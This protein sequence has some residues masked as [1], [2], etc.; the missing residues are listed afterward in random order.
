LN[1]QIENNPSFFIS[2]SLKGIKEYGTKTPLE[3]QNLA[4]RFTEIAKSDWLIHG[5]KP[6]G[7]T[8]GAV[9][10]AL[11]MSGVNT[12]EYYSKI[13]ENLS[14]SQATIKR[15][16]KDLKSDLVERA[17]TS[18]PWGNAVNIQNVTIHL[19]A[20]LQFLDHMENL[21]GNNKKQL[22][23]SE[24]RSSKRRK[25]HYISSPPCIKREKQAMDIKKKKIERAKN[26]LQYL[27]S[28]KNQDG[29][30]DKEIDPYKGISWDAE[31]LD[32]QR[33]LLNDFPEH[34]ILH[35]GIESKSPER[36][37]TIQTKEDL[38]NQEITEADMDEEELKS[39]L[40]SER[41][42]EIFKR[43]AGRTK[44]SNNTF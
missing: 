36:N 25:I 34:L 24:E 5:H 20:L 13:A 12:K 17:R 23:S 28:K 3:I 31:D 4:T 40:R 21:S 38:D 9:L 2:R 27:E 8:G 11:E 43:I 35:G 10:L 18:L 6:V 37:T 19:P 42:I 16:L 26:Y 29:D 32:I 30:D 7:I 1:I 14:I 41:E 39:Y 22:V 15:R 33:Q 44:K